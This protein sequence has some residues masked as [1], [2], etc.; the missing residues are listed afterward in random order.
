MPALKEFHKPTDIPAAL[1]LLKRKS[2]RTIPLAG[3]T[4]LNPRI[5]KE[6]LAEAV[7]DLSGLGLDRIE[8]DADALHL[9]AMATLAAVTEDES[10]RSLADGILAQTAR[11]DAV[12]NVR[13]A[14]TV[15]GTV[16]VAPSDSEFILALLALNAQ[17]SVQSKELDTWPLSQFLTDPAAALDYHQG[18]PTLDYHQGSST[19]DGGL[20]TQVQISLPLPAAAGLARVVRTPSDHPIVAAVAVVT[21]SSRIALGGVAARPLVIEFD[22]AGAAK[23]AV[24]QAIAEAEQYADF[25]GSADYRRAM[26]I[27]MAKRALQRAP[28][29]V[30]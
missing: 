3:G 27:L 14:A 19:L 5:D 21:D 18:S 4:W 25:R 26:G 30:Q 15:G 23:D 13:N 29:R 12:L 9:G 28:G 6:G 22:H 10:C 17:V 20:V 16:V 24:A 7:V 8:R 1:A 11:R 2:P